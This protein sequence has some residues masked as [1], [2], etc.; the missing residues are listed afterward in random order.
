MASH[1]PEVGHSNFLTVSHSA[2]LALCESAVT[3]SPAT[4]LSCISLPC[5]VLVFVH[6]IM[7][8]RALICRF[9]YLCSRWLILVCALTREPTH[10]VVFL[11]SAL[12]NGAARPGPYLCFFLLRKIIHLFIFKR[13]LKHLLMA[14]VAQW[15]ECWPMNQR[16]ASFDSQ[17]GHMPGLQS[18]SPVGGAQ[19]TT[20]H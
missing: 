14:C 11:D 8:G 2:L 20:T 17:S 15:I 18:R 7:G 4:S 1:C 12:T 9:T 19:E 16:V 3:Q 13:F 6:L 10:T 5:T